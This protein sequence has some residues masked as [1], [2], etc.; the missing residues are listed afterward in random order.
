[1]T[2]PSNSNCR[3]ADVIEMPRFC[4]I[5]SQSDTTPD[6]P[7]LPWTA[8]ASPIARACSASA[9]VSVDLPASGWEM[10]AMLRRRAAWAVTTA[11]GAARSV[12][13]DAP[14]CGGIARGRAPRPAGPCAWARIYRPRHVACAHAIVMSSSRHASSHARH[15][16]AQTRQCSCMP[17]WLSHSSPQARQAAMHACRWARVMFAS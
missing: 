10:T 14:A 5:S 13:D 11:G 7:C 3:A 8:P 16:S 6:R 9:S 2:T 1:M 15:A 17:A 4:S 12:T